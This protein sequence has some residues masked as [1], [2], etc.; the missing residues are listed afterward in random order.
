MF[1]KA[2]GHLTYTPD[3]NYTGNNPLY[4]HIPNIFTKAT[5]LGSISRSGAEF[6]ITYTLDQNNMGNLCPKYKHIPN[7]FTKAT[8]L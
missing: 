3:H 4:M 2:I 1:T 8:S 5:S 6:D 7:V